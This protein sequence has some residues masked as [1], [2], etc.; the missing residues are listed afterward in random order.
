MIRLRKR[1]KQSQ[2]RDRKDPSIDPSKKRKRSGSIKCNCPASIKMRKQF[3][4]DE[5]VIEYFWKHE[6][7]TPGVMED[8][9]AQRLPQD[10]KAWVKDRANEGLEWKTIKNMMLAGSP[11]LEKVHPAVRENV[12]SLIPSCYAH[13]ANTMRQLKSRQ[14]HESST[15]DSENTG[16]DD[17]R[18]PKRVHQSQ[19]TL[20]I[21]VSSPEQAMS[22]STGRSTM[23]M[24]PGRNFS[25]AVLP[26]TW[27]LVGLNIT[28]DTTTPSQHHPSDATNQSEGQSLSLHASAVTT[29]LTTEPAASST[30][31]VISD[32]RSSSNSS[33]Q[34]SAQ[35][36]TIDQSGSTPSATCEPHSGGD[37]LSG[38]SLISTAIPTTVPLSSAQMTTSIPAAVP[39]TPATTGVASVTGE[40]TVDVDDDSSLTFRL[41]LSTAPS[42]LISSLTSDITNSGQPADS[43]GSSAGASQDSLG[44]TKQNMSATSTLIAGT[45][46][47]RNGAE[48]HLSP[49]QE[50]TYQQQ[51]EQQVQQPQSESQS[52]PP[53]GKAQEMMLHILR[54][55]AELR[56]Q[57]EA[58]QSYGTEEDAIQIVQSFALPIR[59]MKEALERRN[60]SASQR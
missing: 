29:S 3:L 30:S 12:K 31:T 32:S 52:Q 14:S 7:H 53:P 39:S 26:E 1:D 37:Q 43:Y 4:E 46:T 9:K 56:E 54:A 16:S 57:M 45:L 27:K 50:V 35:Q 11:T 40:A 36:Q 48:S 58:T 18:S 51:E 34:S 2:Y 21:S 19:H 22:T 41:A 17:Q 13:Y 8:I 28:T 49:P 47:E 44:S 23:P 20:P 33:I 42:T 15:Q 60:N 25:T 55:I 24:D 5:V 59:L 38:F 10:L 6:G